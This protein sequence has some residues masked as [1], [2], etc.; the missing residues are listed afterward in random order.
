MLQV[1]CSINSLPTEVRMTDKNEN[2]NIVAQEW[3]DK[4]KELLLMYAALNTTPPNPFDMQNECKPVLME[5]VKKYE[6]DVATVNNN[7][8]VSE[9]FRDTLKS[10]PDTYK[11]FTQIESFSH[12]REALDRMGMGEGKNVYDLFYADLV[13]AIETGKVAN[14]NSYVLLKTLFV[15]WLNTLH[16]CKQYKLCRF[17]NH[18][19]DSC[20]IG[21][22]NSEGLDQIV[23][24]CDLELLSDTEHKILN[25]FI[26]IDNLTGNVS[27]YRILTY[28]V[29]SKYLPPIVGINDVVIWGGKFQDGIP[30]VHQWAAGRFGFVKWQPF[31][32]VIDCYPTNMQNLTDS[33]KEQYLEEL[34]VYAQKSKYLTRFFHEMLNSPYT[35]YV[36]EVAAKYISIMQAVVS[37]EKY[38]GKHML[39]IDPVFPNDIVEMMRNGVT[40]QLIFNPTK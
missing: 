22:I 26:N 28:K 19:T 33:E 20:D 16:I 37:N 34:F 14:N 4:N 18:Y 17:A 36:S 11:H 32:E 3:I 8:A 7:S 35:G 38:W 23:S 10:Q 21:S 5:W 13:T 39:S 24:K 15:I 1:F 6:P 25:N 29:M 27:K 40:H 2:P 30:G 9:S 12:R 31:K